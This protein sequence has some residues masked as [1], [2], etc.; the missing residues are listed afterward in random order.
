MAAATRKVCVLGDFG[1]GKTSLV[2][3]FVHSIFNDKYLTTVGAKIDTKLVELEDG[4]VKLIIWDMAG[5]PGITNNVKTYLRGATGYLL[6]IDGTRS[7]TMKSAID[8]KG[9]AD[10]LIPGKPFVVLINKADLKDR[11]EVTEADKDAL[12][13]LGCVVF[14]SSA[15]SGDNVEE[16]FKV[17]ATSVR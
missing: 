2:G 11:W 4:D 14:E 5:G 15:K 13:K 8:L 10:L 7:A 9:E 17:L 6:V 16:A 1:V 3:K 12:S